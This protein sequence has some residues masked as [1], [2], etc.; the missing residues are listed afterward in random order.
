MSDYTRATVLAILEHL[1]EI[2]AYVYRVTS[3]LNETPYVID[4]DQEKEFD[5]MGEGKTL[6]NYASH[7]TRSVHRNGFREQLL[8]MI[9]DIQ[10]ARKYLT[11]EENLALWAI[12]I[13]RPI[14]RPAV[15]LKTTADIALDKVLFHLN[16]ALL[17]D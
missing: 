4:P 3:P 17:P 7:T 9:I 13:A 5:K 11:D 10:L 16:G 8:D 1:D 14:G 12:Y 15:A 2:E 6:W